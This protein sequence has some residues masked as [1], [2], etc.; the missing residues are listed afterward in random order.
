MQREKGEQS[1]LAW[2]QQ[3]LVRQWL[4]R[5]SWHSTR[6]WALS[7]IT[8][9]LSINTSNVKAS[10]LTSRAAIAPSPSRLTEPLAS[11]SNPPLA[12]AQNCHDSPKACATY[13]LLGTPELSS[14]LSVLNSRYCVL[15]TGNCELGLGSGCPIATSA[16]SFFITSHV[17]SGLLKRHALRVPVDYSANAST[18]SQTSSSQCPLVSLLSATPVPFSLLWLLTSVQTNEPSNERTELALPRLEFPFLFSPPSS[19]S[20]FQPPIACRSPGPP[21][22]L[23]ARLDWK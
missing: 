10:S 6:C 20:P 9:Q 12:Y 23:S 11:S 3:S 21:F 14:R 1:E 19:P 8:N 22:C 4:C 16:L 18:S 13:G 5:C 15:G 2:T 17:T 7:T